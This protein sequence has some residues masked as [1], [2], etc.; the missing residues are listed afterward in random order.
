MTRCVSCVVRTLAGFT[1]LASC[2]TGPTLTEYAEGM[3]ALVLE[4]D[5]EMLELANDVSSEEEPT[6]EVIRAYVDEEVVILSDFVSAFRLLEPPAQAEE[7]HATAL[8]VLDRLL[9]AEQ[10]LA[11]EFALDADL[12][13]TDN[14]YEVLSRI[15]QSDAMAEALAADADLNALCDAAQERFDATQEEAL[16]AG[17]PW[18]PSELKEVVRVT[19]SCE[20]APD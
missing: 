16:F 7:L 15:E 18:V 12:E 9:S 1:L 19:L 8:R 10:A 17:T 20:A 14:L 4:T 3:E 6:L 11:A 5:A 13:G 2:S